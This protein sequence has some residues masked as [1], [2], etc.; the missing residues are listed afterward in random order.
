MDKY[1]TRQ[2]DDC[3]RLRTTIPQS[4]VTLQLILYWNCVRL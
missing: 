4:K 3:L 2:H 1:L